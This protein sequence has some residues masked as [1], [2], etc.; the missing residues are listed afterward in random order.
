MVQFDS[1]NVVFRDKTSGSVIP[2]PVASGGTGAVTA[3]AAR[4][5]LGL[6]IGTNVQAY[7]ADL[8]TIA[9]LTST[10]D[11]SF[12]VGSTTGWVQ[13]SGATA[14]T[15]LGLSSLVNLPFATAV[16]STA[17]AFALNTATT[18][19]STANKTYALTSPTA[20]GQYYLLR[21]SAGSTDAIGTIAA[22]AGF[23]FNTSYN[24]LVFDATNESAL[25]IRESTANL[26][27]YPYLGAS[28]VTLST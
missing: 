7:D 2:I 17:A 4:T 3:S 21:C 11:G 5:A 23:K 28:A 8:T 24:K 14:R 22:P 25:V 26:G 20:N 13:E 18:F 16:G 12:I 15:S 9:A 27:V 10:T 6:A 19:G 1:K